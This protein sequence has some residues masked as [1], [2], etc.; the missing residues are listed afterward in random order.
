MISLSEQE[1][2]EIA[3]YIKRN[4]GVNL[5]KKSTLIEGRLG[6]YIKNKGFNSI[7]EYFEFAK[8]D[9]SGEEM[10][11]LIT[12]LTT[13]H[14]FFMRENDHFEFV[15]EKVLPW[16]E[17]LPERNDLRLWSA[18]CS[19]G[20]EPYGLSIY[21]LEYKK[22]APGR[23][24]FDTTILATDISEKALATASRGIYE[25][26][27]LSAMS[28]EWLE[29]YFD[30]L[31]NDTYRVKPELRANVAYK[32]FNLLDPI[33]ASKPFH[34]IFCR[35]V[36]IYFDSETRSKLVK[37]FC[38]AMAPGGYLFTGHSESLTNIKHELKYLQPS[39][40]RKPLE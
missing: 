17:T 19:S 26:N 27:N 15:V 20:E 25:Y 7:G 11:T 33:M 38:D 28:S 2:S 1:L 5:E 22:R 31:G 39:V 13:N 36:M 37:R 24:S 4:Y 32:K 14:T 3:S 9:P 34:V 29:R 10:S 16:V 18:G 8:N 30:N 6:C 40:Y 35:N 12:R 21:L 23:N